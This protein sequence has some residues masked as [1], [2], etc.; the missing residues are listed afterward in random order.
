[1]IV[2]PPHCCLATG[3]LSRCRGVR[4]LQGDQVQESPLQRLLPG[5]VLW[6]T[7]GVQATPEGMGL[8]TEATLFPSGFSH[9]P[10]PTVATAPTTPR[11]AEGG[12]AC[13]WA[14]LQEVRLNLLPVIVSEWVQGQLKGE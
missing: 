11:G 4:E 12:P 6:Q 1:M 9:H 7:P 8:S 2:A 14:P 10:E 13:T 3:W 5:G